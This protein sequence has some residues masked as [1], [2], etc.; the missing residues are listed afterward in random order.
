MTEA[1]QQPKPKARR[2]TRAPRR[3][4]G[5]PLTIWIVVVAAFGALTALQGIV[6]QSALG[7]ATSAF[8]FLC[9]WGLWGWQRWAYYALLV[10]LAIALGVL[11]LALFT[12][13]QNLVPFIIALVAGAITIALS[14]PRLD[15]FR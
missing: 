6:Q 5:Q 14:H 7:L 8:L 3:E 11:L 10:V 2:A 9:A 15:E 4:R 13:T 1:N 12:T